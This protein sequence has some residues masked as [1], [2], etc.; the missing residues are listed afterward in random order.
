MTFTHVALPYRGDVDF[1]DAAVPFLEEGAARDDAIMAVTCPRK[2][3]MLR[4]EVRAEIRFIDSSIFYEHP[5]RIM[6]KVLYELEDQARAGRRLRI[7]GEPVWRGRDPLATVEWQR[8]EAL[9][10]VVFARSDASIMCPY[11]VSLPV[12]ILDGARRTHPESAH[13]VARR[14]NPAYLRPDAFS[15]MCDRAPL[16]PAPEDSASVPVGSPDMKDLRELVAL[17]ARQHGMTGGPL[18]HLLVAVTEVATNALTHGTPPILFRVWPEGD[19]LVCEVADRGH[20]KPDGQ[21]GPGLIP[22]REAEL[23]RLGLWA[24]R[25]L[26]D[27]VQVR[28]G[29]TGTQVRI[30]TPL[31]A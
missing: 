4:E 16:T 14:V 26:C 21:P 15:A 28:T 6:S 13:G 31:C 5:A 27:I 17:H 24:V 7:L 23:P 1:L 9:V 18:H 10:N 22:P 12:G 20:W 25:M 3:A 29:P 19:Q 11:D 8:V 2:L 30:R